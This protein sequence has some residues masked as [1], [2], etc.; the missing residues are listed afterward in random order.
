MF[1]EMRDRFI[2]KT[3]SKTT[4]RY[5]TVKPRTPTVAAGF[6]ESL[7]CLIDSMSK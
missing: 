1:K 2:T 5:V 7:L 3:L 6:T 4:G